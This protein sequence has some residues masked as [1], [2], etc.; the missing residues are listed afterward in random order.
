M[1]RS[2]SAISRYRKAALATFGSGRQYN[3]DLNAAYNIAARGLAL[4]I[5]PAAAGTVAIQG[6]EIESPAR[7]GKS[8]GRASRMPIVLADIWAYVARTSA[9]ARISA[10]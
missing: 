5:K 4:L 10:A 3:A 6:A 1:L 7:T 8:S 2:R 9:A